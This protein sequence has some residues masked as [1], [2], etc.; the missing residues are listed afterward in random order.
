[1]SSNII[2]NDGTYVGDI[3]LIKDIGRNMCIPKLM[4]TTV[5]MMTISN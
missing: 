5:D 3:L 4:G 2:R 1:M